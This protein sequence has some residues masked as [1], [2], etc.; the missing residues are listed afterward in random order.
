MENPFFLD[1]YRT[2]ESDAHSRGYQVVVANTDYDSEQLVASVQLM[3]GWRVAGLAAIV[4]EM[5]SDLVDALA[6]SKIPTALYDAGTPKQNIAKV[7]VDY[8]KGIKKTVGYLSSLGHRHMAFVGHH[9][10]LGPISEGRKAF[11]EMV[12]RPCP[13]RGVPYLCRLR[14]ARRRTPSPRTLKS[15]LKATAILC[16]NDFMAVGVLRELREQGLEVP[17]DVSVTGFDNIKLAEF[18]SPALT[19]V[20]LPRDQIGHIIFES[21]VSESKSTQGSPQETVIDPELVVRESTGVVRKS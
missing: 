16:V 18:C 13:R 2:L 8:R 6:A 17:R 14:W 15:G 19:T 5:D 9:S 1:I 20:H 21:L 10:T 12:S 7:R 3:I 11:L 4:S